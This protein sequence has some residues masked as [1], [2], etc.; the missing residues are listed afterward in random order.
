MT[1][2]TFQ[3]RPC[4]G[5]VSLSQIKQKL[6]EKISS[7]KTKSTSI[8]IQLSS[9]QQ[10]ESAIKNECTKFMGT[11]RLKLQDILEN[12]LSVNRSDYHSA[13]FVGNHCDVIVERYA[14]ITEVLAS[15]PEVKE[16]Y[17][18]FFLYYKS[19]H[20]LMKACRFLTEKELDEV[21]F[22]CEQIGQV[23][24]KYFK[25]S[26]PPK[27]DDLI[28]VVPQ[29][30]RKWNTIGGLREE[31]IEAFHNTSKWIVVFDSFQACFSPFF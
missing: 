3:C 26:I 8:T 12:K 2:E 7:L 14:E 5:I 22:C 25:S 1:E 20:F 17:D 16:K 11:T 18:K 9:L 21:D 13:C 29:F 24:P 31:K 30:A 6:L 4:S 27:L 28:F 15:K 19:L 23:Y 10:E